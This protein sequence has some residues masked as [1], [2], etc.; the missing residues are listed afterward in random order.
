[1][2]QGRAETLRRRIE[3]QQRCLREAA[4]QYPVSVYQSEML[5][6][7][8]EVAELERQPALEATKK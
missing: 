7:E 2:K 3:V 8:P 4:D 5:K 6:A 1:M